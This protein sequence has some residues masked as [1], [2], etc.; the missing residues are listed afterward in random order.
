MDSNST[1]SATPNQQLIGAAQQ[2]SLELLDIAMK[3]KAQINYV[4]GLKN[5]AI[6][7]ACQCGSPSVLELLL[8]KMPE[9]LVYL[10]NVQGNTPLHLALDG[11][12]SEEVTM[13][14]V[15]LILKHSP[16]LLTRNKDG[17]TCIDLA[18]GSVKEYL[19][20]HIDNKSPTKNNKKMQ[21]SF[22]DK[23]DIDADDDDD[24]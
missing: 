15:K 22:L 24:E 8:N 16:L 14:I 9:N 3:R 1:E 17:M 2:D 10:K 18:G 11:K 12:H 19:Q 13:K 21:I 7:Y 20:D 5:T 4:D 23:K 6:H